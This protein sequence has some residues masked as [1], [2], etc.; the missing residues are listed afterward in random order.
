MR[1]KVIIIFYFNFQYSNFSIYSFSTNVII[2]KIV[3]KFTPVIKRS[4]KCTFALYIKQLNFV[5]NIFS[6]H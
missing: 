3:Q 2:I 5:Y 6:K 1:L 4:Q